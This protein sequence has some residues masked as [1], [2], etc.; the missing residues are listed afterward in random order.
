MIV[1]KILVAI[2]GSP[3]AKKALKLAITMAGKMESELVALSV[4]APPYVPPEPYG[5]AAA[6]LQ[7]AVVDY[8]S[9]LAKGAVEQ[10]KKAG[11]NAEWRVESG[12]PADTICHTAD[13]LNA[14]MIV[15]GSR[16]GSTL[17]RALLGSVSDRV[18]HI[19]EIPVLIVH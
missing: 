9:S 2:D 6:G 3:G 10:A 5:F 16:G 13:A 17:R 12:S 18:V 15:V 4:A 14:D 1:K 11:I 7:A 8:A 19:S